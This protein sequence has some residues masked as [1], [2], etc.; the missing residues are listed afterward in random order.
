MSGP[1]VYRVAHTTEYSYSDYVSA[2]YGRAH[3]LPRRSD[4]QQVL[5]TTIQIDPGPDELRSHT[6][7]FGN[8]STYY[9][10]RTPHQRLRVVASS[11]VAIERRAASSEELN[12]ITW[13]EARDHL[14]EDVQARAFTV[15]SPLITVTRSVASYA[16]ASF[17]DGRPLGDAINDLMAR[18]HHDVEYVA[19]ATNVKT[20]LGE[21]LRGRRGVCQD[22]AQLTVGCLRSAGVPARYVSGYLETTP[23]PGQPK[24][25]GA[26]ASHAWAAVRVPGLDWVD[27]DPTN[28][29]LVDDRYVVSAWGRDYSDVPPLKG[30]ILTQAEKSAMEVRVDV[31]RIG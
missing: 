4:G 19:G 29:Q 7:F 11:D 30:V 10:V 17:T 18:I 6:D 2:S 23:P 8:H 15:N 16:A 14:G 21:V 28:N 31:T 25:Q 22:F 1:R 5:A 20:T 12:S 9:C 13:E 26:D 27:L 3:L 24:L